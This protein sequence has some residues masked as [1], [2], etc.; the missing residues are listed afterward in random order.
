MFFNLIVCCDSKYGIG[1]NNNIP[2][3]F[4]KDIKQFKMLTL[5]NKTLE[6]KY[7]IVIMGKNTYN[8]IPNYYRPLKNR[9][10]II[11]SNTLPPT[12]KDKLEDFDYIIHNPIFFNN[13]NFLLIY[14]NTISSF[15]NECF[16]IGGSQIY[17]IFLDFKLINKIYLTK[18]NDS[19]YNCNVAFEFNKYKK[20]FE[21][22]ENTYFK[23]VNKTSRTMNTLVYCIYSYTNK[24]ENKFIKTVNKIL[25]S[26][27]YNLDRSQ[28]GTLSIF[29]KSFTYDIRNYRLP[30]FTHRKVFLRGIIEE[31]LFFISGNTDTKILENKGINIWKG[32]TSRK[33]L[34]SRGLNHLKEGDMG[35]GYSHQLRNWGGDNKNK[36]IDQLEY[37]IDQI[38]NNPTSRRIL[39]SYWNP[40]DLDKV[41]LPACFTEGTLILTNNGYKE[42]QDV[43]I[44]D[45]LY[46]HKG[47]WESILNKQIKEYN[48]DI[49]T[50]KCNYNTKQIETTQEHPFY[51][52]EYIKKSDGTIRN[53]TEFPYWCEAKN[54][55]TDKHV[56]CFPINKN[57]ITPEFNI[58]KGLNKTKTININKKLDKLEEYY[59]MGYYVGDGWIDLRKGRH[60]FSIVFKKHKPEVYNLISKIIHLTFKSET[61][62]ISTHTCSNKIWWTILKEFGHLARNKIIPEWVQNSPKEYIQSF[63]DGYTA[64]DGTVDHEYTTVSK[65]LA[66]G[67]QRLYAKLGKILSVKFQ[68]KP[69]TCII[70][71]RIVN[72]NDLYHMKLIK[73]CKKKYVKIVDDDFIYFPIKEIKKTTQ[74]KTVYNF[75]VNNDNSYTVQNLSVHNCHLL[76]QFN[77]NIDTNELSCS[78]YQRSNDF[79]LANNFNVC[80]AAILTFMLC[81]ICNLKPGKIIHTIGNI[82][83]YSNQIE[84]TKEFIKNKPYNA[85]LLFI[86]D[87]DDKIKKIEDFKYEHFK[88][89]FYNSYKKYKIDMSV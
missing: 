1:K 31:L 57:N 59:M 51:V 5:G 33:F 22:I 14:I 43:E 10:N 12:E 56:I 26:G 78:F 88:L 86:D 80:S 47:N 71:G 24:E 39:F 46:T 52:K 35:R 55:E 84:V 75:E 36:G 61:D 49:Y 32:H 18:I 25:N 13:I 45:K 62:K 72:Q 9:I 4:S 87:P 83:I 82:H 11:L 89:L 44:T 34:D 6:E 68:K 21:L 69:S 50:I 73:K 3:K 60:V 27:I 70:Q 41:A 7:N 2:W 65:N 20:Q 30:L 16:V 23:D 15:T 17:N 67:L 48:G 40:S 28:V 58:L 85:P 38:K 29:G 53:Y 54:L 81:K 79:C 19:N 63:I 42:I 37:V 74:I 66:Y 77:V 8:S 64:A 76:Y